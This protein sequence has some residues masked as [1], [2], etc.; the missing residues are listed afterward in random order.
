M[1]YSSYSFTNASKS[2]QPSV[3]YGTVNQATKTR[4]IKA[5]K[6]NGSPDVKHRHLS[7][8]ATT[9][10]ALSVRF[11]TAQ[12]T[13]LSVYSAKQIASQKHVEKYTYHGRLYRVKYYDVPPTKRVA[14]FFFKEYNY[15]CRGHAEEG[16]HLTRGGGD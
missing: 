9:A 8:E 5:P 12:R 2:I 1:V 16:R 4:P 10:S 3:L 13:L 15:I 14:V 6:H 7:T 11:C